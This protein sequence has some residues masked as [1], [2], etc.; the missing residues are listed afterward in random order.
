MQ[1]LS[2]VTFGDRVRIDGGIERSG[3]GAASVAGVAHRGTQL[4]LGQVDH[5]ER[6]RDRA[7]A[8]DVGFTVRAVLFLAREYVSR[9]VAG[10]PEIKSYLEA[11]AEDRE[12]DNQLLL[13]EDDTP[14]DERILI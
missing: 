2:L 6:E 8:H 4:R 5:T 9:M 12:I 3:L 10:V 11:L 7:I 14:S 13:G 1:R